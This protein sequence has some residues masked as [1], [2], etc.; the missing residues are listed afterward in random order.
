MSQQHNLLLPDAAEVL[1]E[2][3][4]VHRVLGETRGPV[5]YEGALQPELE[6][7]VR[8]ALGG[9]QA[10]RQVVEVRDGV[11][12][13]AEAAD[14]DDGIWRVESAALVGAGVAGWGGVI[15]DPREEGGRGRHSRDAWA[16]DRAS[17]GR[18]GLR[19][20]GYDAGSLGAAEN[21]G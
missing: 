7:R 21:Q 5:P 4:D 1:D 14:G 12:A 19:N 18:S 20:E 2:G 6:H 9:V 17:H 15:V 3:G 8:G 13:V 11:R 16:E 10:G